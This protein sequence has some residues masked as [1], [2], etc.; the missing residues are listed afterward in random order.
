VDAG[1]ISP[2]W[3]RDPPPPPPALLEA[4][5]GNRQRTEYDRRRYALVRALLCA[6]LYPQIAVKQASS[7][8]ARGPDK[9]AAKGMREA[10]IH[11]SSVLKKGANHICIVYQEKSKTTGPDKAAKLYL[12][13]TTG[14][15]LKSILAFGGELEASEDRRQIIVD[16]WFRVDASPQD[17]TVFRRLRSLL[18]GVLRRKIDAPQADLDELGLRVVDWIVR[19]LVLDTQQA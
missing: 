6:A 9:Y 13:D 17:I 12:R 14:V 18:D 11:P 2:G 8:G 10:E 19:L 16:G 5:H 15:S 7:G 1:F 4:L 3:V